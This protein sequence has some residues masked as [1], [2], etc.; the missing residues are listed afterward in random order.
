MPSS[1]PLPTQEANL[2]KKILVTILF[3]KFNLAY[4]RKN[5]SQTT[6]FS[7]LRNA[8]NWNNTEKVCNMLKKF[9]RNFQN[10]EVGFSF[11]LIVFKFA[12][13][14]IFP[15]FS[16]ETLSMKGLILNYCNKKNEAYECAQRGLRNDV[17]SHVCWHVYGLLQRSDRKYD[18]SIKCY[19]N[20]LKCDP[21]SWFKMKRKKWE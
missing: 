13:I 15:D 19:R 9:S 10:M 6:V 21:V 5:F 20:A 16:S 3:F 12:L 2:F 14:I 18:E 1:Q 8:M 17:K 11:N 7:S 4:F